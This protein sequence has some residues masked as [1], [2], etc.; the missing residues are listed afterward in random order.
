M[1]FPDFLELAA[2]AHEMNAGDYS[3]A[4]VKAGAKQAWNTILDWGN[5]ITLSELFKCNATQKL[6]NASGTKKDKKKKI[7][8]DY[9]IPRATAAR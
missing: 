5:I 6:F 9:E 4:S 1:R 8:H 7:K 3:E 2:I